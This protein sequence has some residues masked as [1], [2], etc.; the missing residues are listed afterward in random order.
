M[1]LTRSKHT[2]RRHIASAHLRSVPELHPATAPPYE[3]SVPDPDRPDLNRRPSAGNDRSRASWPIR[4]SSP[5]HQPLPQ[6]QRSQA[7]H[8]DH[9]HEQHP[10]HSSA[11]PRHATMPAR[12]HPGFTTQ[13]CLPIYPDL[14]IS[15]RYTSRPLKSFAAVFVS[16]TSTTIAG[17]TASRTSASES[18]CNCM[19]P[20]ASAHR[21]LQSRT[22]PQDISRPCDTRCHIVCRKRILHSEHQHASRLQHAHKL[23]QISHRQPAWH[24]LQHDIAVH[25]RETLLRER[26][27]LRHTRHVVAVRI[28]IQRLC[29]ANHLLRDIHAHTRRKPPRQ[30]LRQPPHAAAKIQRCSIRVRQTPTSRRYPIT[31]AISISP[32]SKNSATSHPPSVLSSSVRIAHSASRFASASQSLRSSSRSINASSH[33][34]QQ[35]QATTRLKNETGL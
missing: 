4:R 22:Q 3:Y 15:L 5:D 19:S 28:L 18:R 29:P 24:M 30:R 23:P 35:A 7:A 20:L 25:K 34:S 16:R 21:E 12:S 8:R 26:Q 10:T 9:S 33:S 27:P 2:Q 11:S 13:Y 6:Q 32:V 1:P 17:R 14:G 31:V